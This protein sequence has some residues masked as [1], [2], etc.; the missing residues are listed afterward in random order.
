[1]NHDDVDALAAA[2]W[3]ALVNRTGGGAAITNY[4]VVKRQTGAMGPNAFRLTPGDVRA[5]V[6][7]AAGNVSKK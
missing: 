1:M 4:L 3:N 7:Q 2:I 5:I 6:Q